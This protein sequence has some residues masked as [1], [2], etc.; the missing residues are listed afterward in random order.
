MAAGIGALEDDD[1]FRS[2]C[3]A[4]ME[5]RAWAAQALKD[6]G[7]TV[8]NSKTNFLFAKHPALDGKTL[9]LELKK[10]GILVRHFDAPRISAYN[11]ITVGTKEQMQAL[12]NTIRT[13]LEEQL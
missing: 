13:I 9:Y 6:L 3:R 10:R 11:R 12:L 2:N 1:Y 5:T 7:F 8:T 4:I